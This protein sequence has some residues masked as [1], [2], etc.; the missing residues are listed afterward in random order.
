MPVDKVAYF[1]MISEL[2]V[3]YSLIV[4]PVGKEPLGSLPA[5]LNASI[6]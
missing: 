6:S 5:T 2:H 3:I 1:G 4:L